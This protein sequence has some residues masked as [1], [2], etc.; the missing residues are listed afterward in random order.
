M[1]FFSYIVCLRVVNLTK[2][3]KWEEYFINHLFLFNLNKSCDS[4]SITSWPR[5]AYL[6]FSMAKHWKPKKSLAT[7]GHS[8]IVVWPG[9]L[10]RSN[11]NNS[12]GTIFTSS[13]YNVLKPSKRTFNRKFFIMYLREL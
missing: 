12:H 1:I 8:G 6:M 11:D 9:R 7:L 2:L 5:L 3:R 4:N 13:F 10:F